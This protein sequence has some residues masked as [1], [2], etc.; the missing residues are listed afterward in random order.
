MT[1]PNSAVD[2]LYKVPTYTEDDV[3]TMGGLDHIRNFPARY[4]G[5]YDAPAGH[6]HQIKEAIDNAVDEGFVHPNIHQPVVVVVA[7][8]PKSFQVV[9]TDAGRGVPLGKIR[10][11]FSRPRTSAKWTK[12]YGGSSSG[13][14]GEGIKGVS[15]LAAEFVAVSANATGIGMISMQAG[16]V[17]DSRI[18]MDSGELST[19]TSVFFE[20]DPAFL[21]TANTFTS[22]GLPILKELLLFLGA[23]TPENITFHLYT[24]TTPLFERGE[25]TTKLPSHSYKRH[26]YR[27]W[28]QLHALPARPD[29]TNHELPKLTRREFT[30]R[31][32]GVVEA[33]FWS[34]Q[35]RT[36]HA[37]PTE[38]QAVGVD[39]DIW[40]AGQAL[41]KFGIAGSVNL[42][43]V[44]DRSSY[45]IFGLQCVLRERLSQVI[46][47][48][49]TRTFVASRYQFPLCGSVVV[50]VETPKFDNQTKDAY[51]D[52]KF[53]EVYRELLHRLIPTNLAVWEE[54]YGYLENDIAIQLAKFNNR[55]LGL[56]KG[57]HQLRLDDRKRFRVCDS[58]D[59]KVTELFIAEGDSAGNAV[60][61]V[62]DSSYQ[63]VFLMSG[64]FTNVIRAKPEIL[65]KSELFK[66]LTKVIGVNFGG[67]LDTLNFSKIIMLADADPDGY[68]IQALLMGLLYHMSPELF[69]RGHVY[70]AEPPLYTV[71]LSPN[72]M[73]YVRDDR[74][75][76]EMR[77]QHL[78]QRVLRLTLH[79]RFTGNVVSPAGYLTG[80]LFHAFMHRVL[81][82]G[83]T[84]KLWANLLN[85]EPGMLEALVPA[86]DALQ[87]GRIDTRAIQTILGVNQVTHHANSNTL[88]VTI[89]DTDIV[90]ALDQL[91]STITTH[92]IPAFQ[93]NHW[94]HL[95]PMLH[96]TVGASY[97]ISYSE[98]YAVTETLD[99]QLKTSRN[100]GLGKMPARD[101][102]RSCVD[103]VTRILRR[104]GE[105]KDFGQIVDMLGADP[106][107]RKRLF[108]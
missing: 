2:P 6:V 40:L 69:V 91:A 66:D 106:A 80:D 64:K 90:V 22:E 54:L 44:H 43:P 42:V 83:R 62:R 18:V 38:L 63:A 75:L 26:L 105:I 47:H 5:R 8:L 12:A 39:I 36:E 53:L 46:D 56:N 32:F 65:A 50:R 15:A 79:D 95:V 45:H 25:L 70:R 27:M 24:T 97:Y 59:A 55:E 81:T 107:A 49:E 98:L 34:M 28:E 89:G 100:K 17:L 58:T 7:Q 9:V 35:V 76:D 71:T 99:H 73:I 4:L 23:Y 104:V 1:N 14:H 10:D 101:L 77:I 37:H 31:K 21:T 33:P 51:H 60:N 82:L 103:P 85:L 20:T 108:D 16:T 67:S 86:V 52:N 102:Y 72:K 74:A 30:E 41:D 11:L 93:D 48:A 87:P 78:Y 92:L 88:G 3:K 68:H 96:P 61:T 13:V 94:Y 29:M 84:I 57:L 19:G